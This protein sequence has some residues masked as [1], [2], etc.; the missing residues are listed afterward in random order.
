[1]NASTVRLQRAL[2]IAVAA[3]GIAAI[4]G[5]AQVKKAAPSPAAGTMWLY[6]ERIRLTDG[7]YIVAERGYLFAP[8]VRSNPKSEVIGVEVYRFRAD[9]TANPKT[10]PIFFLPGGPNFA[11]LE[12]NLSR[13]GYFEREIKPYLAAAD[14][15]VV[16]QRGIGSSKPTTSCER[17]AAVPV[18]APEATRAK[19]VSDAAA[20]CKA[21]WQQWVGDLKALTVPEVAADANDVRKALGYDK[22]QIWGGSFGSHWTFAIMR[23]YPQIVERVVLRGL[24]GPDNTYDSPEGLDNALKRIAA[25]ADTAPALKDKKPAGGF[26]KALT[27]VIAKL[28]ASPV[29][30]TVNDSA[31]GALT[32]RVDG[33]AVREIAVSNGRTWPAIVIAL[34]SGDYT[35]AARAVIN[36]HTSPGIETASYYM[37]DCGSG[38]TPERDAQFAKSSAVRVVGDPN[39]EYRV[40]CPVWQS[41]NGDAFRRMYH[42]DIPAVI[43]QG[44]WDVNTP[45]ENALELAPF[46]K[47]HHFVLVKGGSHASLSEAWAANA[48]FRRELVEYFATGDMKGLPNEVALPPVKW[49]VR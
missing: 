46:F 44:D 13:P 25:A 47:N 39:W 22:I 16:G 37:L 7:S 9:A 19:A 20:K 15:V 1:M 40:A 5:A 10:P 34:N 26:Y 12:N 43:V 21:F 27:D 49:V 8:L 17:P 29:M 36:R 3:L 28:D 41:D 45:M 11:G 30:V 4:P 2:G 42:T 33:D 24:E 23:Y 18:D 6:P 31:K 38:I 35:Q 14:F 32:V 48:D